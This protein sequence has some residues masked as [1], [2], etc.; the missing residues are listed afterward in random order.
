MRKTC[1][2]WPARLSNSV[3]QNDLC[4]GL[5]SNPIPTEYFTDAIRLS[6][7]FEIFVGWVLIRGVLRRYA[8]G[9]LGLTLSGSEDS[10][11]AR[12]LTS[13][14]LRTHGRTAGR[15]ACR[16]WTWSAVVSAC[17]LHGAELI[18]RTWLSLRCQCGFLVCYRTRSFIAA[19]AKFRYWS[20][21]KSDEFRPHNF[22]VI[23]Q[24]S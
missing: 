7:L 4:V 1:V 16:K 11:A 20:L 9:V 21:F 24:A 15:H 18:F 3:S 2:G 13:N 10:V 23:F 19:F 22:L 8:S 14:A 5:E 12:D 17:E 6:S